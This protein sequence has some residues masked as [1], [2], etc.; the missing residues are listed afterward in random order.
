[1]Q[2]AKKFIRTT[3]A[4]KQAIESRNKRQFIKFY[5]RVANDLNYTD[6][7]ICFKFPEI[8]VSFDIDTTK[9]EQAISPF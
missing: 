9:L 3:E 4:K 5:Q 7:E 2:N 6:A 8:N 1:M